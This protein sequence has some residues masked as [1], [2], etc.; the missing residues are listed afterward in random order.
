VAAIN[1]IHHVRLRRRELTRQFDVSRQM[2]KIEETCVPSYLHRNVLA[3]GVAWWRLFAAE[4]FYRKF[5]PPGDILDFGAATGELG[6]LVPASTPYEFIEADEDMARTLQANRPGAVRRSLE[7]LKPAQYA[8]IFALDSLEHNEDV[9]GIVDL[10]IASMRDDGVLIISGPTENFLYKAGRRIARF[11]GHYHKTTIYDIER[12]LS[13]RVSLV[14]RRI[15]PLGIP[16]F[17]ITCWQK[18]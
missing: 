12:I 2:E 11:N 4:G 7:G 1:K 18:K 17:S 15:L 6:H 9:A 14:Q 13:G 16:L 10:L 5:A 8:A 3:S